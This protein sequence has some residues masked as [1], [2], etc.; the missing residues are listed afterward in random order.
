MLAGEVLIALIDVGRPSPL[1]VAPFPRQSFLNYIRVIESIWAQA[2]KQEHV[3]FIY[4]C[5]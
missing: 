4:L 5:S 1:L 2:S 3:G